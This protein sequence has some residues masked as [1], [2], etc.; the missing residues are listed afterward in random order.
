VFW[1]CQWQ[2]YTQDSIKQKGCCFPK[3]TLKHLEMKIMCGSLKYYLNECERWWVSVSANVKELY[4]PKSQMCKFLV[5][6]LQQMI[7]QF[8]PKNSWQPHY[9]QTN[10]RADHEVAMFENYLFIPCTLMLHIIS[11]C[12]LTST[13]CILF[14]A[15]EGRL[16]N[17]YTFCFAL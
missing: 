12:V 6:H 2:C 17:Y 3:C 5:H 14:T 4:H 1:L 9:T 8:K 13:S 15:F 11:Q 10:N 16:S 7:S